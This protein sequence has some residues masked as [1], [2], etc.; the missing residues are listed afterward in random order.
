LKTLCFSMDRFRTQLVGCLR[1][2]DIDSLPMDVTPKRL[3]HLYDFIHQN[4]TDFLFGD[5]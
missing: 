3:G 4:T 2:K 1:G 5:I